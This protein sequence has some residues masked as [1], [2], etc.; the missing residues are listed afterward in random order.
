M[1]QTWSEQGK[2]KQW[3]L[4][5]THEI[6]SIKPSKLLKISQSKTDDPVPTLP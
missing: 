6:S 4:I 1:M 5:K 2:Q 3:N